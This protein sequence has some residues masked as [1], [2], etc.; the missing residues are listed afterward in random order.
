MTG[1]IQLE[2]EAQAFAEAAAKPPLLFTLGPAKG[3]IAL[4][5]RKRAW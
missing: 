2:L 3:R 5:R 1:R 4:E